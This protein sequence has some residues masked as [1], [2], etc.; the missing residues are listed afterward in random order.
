MAEGVTD[1][2]ADELRQAAREELAAIY[3]TRATPPPAIPDETFRRLGQLE[4]QTRLA[5][6]ETAHYVRQLAQLRTQIIASRLRVHDLLA[7]S[8]PQTPNADAIIAVFD[9]L[10]AGG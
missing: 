1:W 8:D 3:A 5:D 2:R 7:E 10:L 4:R 9:E 6:R